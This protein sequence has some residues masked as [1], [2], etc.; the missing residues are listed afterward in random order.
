MMRKKKTGLFITLEGPEGSGKTTVAKKLIERLRRK[1]IPCIYTIEPGGT[2][3]TKPIREV[4]LRRSHEK[5]FPMAELFL[6]EADRVQHVNTV[7]RP[8]LDLGKLVLC[9]RYSDSTSAYQ[10]YGRGLDIHMVKKMNDIATE[11]LKPDLTIL[12]DVPS[13]IGLVRAKKASGSLD[14]VESEKKAFHN[15]LRKGY[16]AIAGQEPDRFVVLSAKENLAVVVEK[17]WKAL[18]KVLIQKKMFPIQ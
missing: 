15:R 1:K 3:L 12:I 6:F 11:N 5:L 4:L 18:E 2:F 10:G 17:A 13:Q 7:I 14:R 8:A 16:L 9:V